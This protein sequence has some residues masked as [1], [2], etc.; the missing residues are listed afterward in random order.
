[1]G[2]MIVVQR[3]PFIKRWMH[4]LFDCPTFWK[5][6]SFVCPICGKKYRCYWDGHDSYG[7]INVC[8][9]CVKVTDVL[10][11]LEES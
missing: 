6:P 3:R 10:E 7:F 9:T 11:K 4:K 2:I 8:N 5:K 1:M